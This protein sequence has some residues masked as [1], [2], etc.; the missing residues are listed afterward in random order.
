MSRGLQVLWAGMSWLPSRAL[1]STY[2]FCFHPVQKKNEQR[3]WR[4]ASQ[5]EADICDQ[6]AIDHLIRNG[7]PTSDDIVRRLVE[8]NK[9]R[10][11]HLNAMLASVT[12][13]TTR[14][15][16][17]AFHAI[18]VPMSCIP[19]PPSTGDRRAARKLEECLHSGEMD[20]ERPK[21]RAACGS[22]FAAL[23]KHFTRHSLVRY[24]R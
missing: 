2:G 10:A 23:T 16:T 7:A 17:M 4:S 9:I 14:S 1:V 3:V 15:P 21:V 11:D 5:L 13:V 24:L 6:T 19:C 12:T 8:Q 18:S 20:S 22:L